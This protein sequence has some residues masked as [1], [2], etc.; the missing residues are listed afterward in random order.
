[1]VASHAFNKLPAAIKSTDRADGKRTQYLLCATLHAVRDLS[2]DFTALSFV[3]PEKVRSVQ[4]RRARQDWREVVNNNDQLECINGA[5][6]LKHY[7]FRVLAARQRC[8]ER[9]RGAGHNDSACWYRAD[10]FSAACVA[11]RF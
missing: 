7:E 6:R 11:K 8:V 5:V 9:R 3:A 2:I 10:W 1:L 4:T